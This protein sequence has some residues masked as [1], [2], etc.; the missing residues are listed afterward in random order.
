MRMVYYGSVAIVESV[1]LESRKCCV[2]SRSWNRHR[3]DLRKNKNSEFN[4]LTNWKTKL[5]MKIL[6]RHFLSKKKGKQK[7]ELNLMCFG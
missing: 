1:S 3:Q 6:K 7:V 5:L 2:E 4:K